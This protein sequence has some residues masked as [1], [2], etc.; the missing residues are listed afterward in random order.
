MPNITM[1]GATDVGRVRRANEDSYRL[2][3]HLQA[4][5]VCDGMG[6]HAAGEVASQQAVDVFSAYL[7]QGSTLGTA[8]TPP[9]MDE[10]SESTTPPV[11]AIRLAN[12]SVFETAQAKRSMRGMGTTLVSVLFHEGFAAI[13]HVGDSRAYR[14]AGGRLEPLTEDHSLLAELK[15]Q[16]EITAEQEKGLP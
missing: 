3:P 4:L 13:Y 2:L 9:D 14:F 5:V 16:G 1:T 6:G 11:Q 10:L 15:A 7:E 12:R 8:L